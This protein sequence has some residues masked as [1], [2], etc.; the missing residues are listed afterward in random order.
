MKRALAI[1][2]LVSAILAVLLLFAGS[3]AKKIRTPAP[4]PP[5]DYFQLAEKYFD[6]ADYANAVRAY[7]TY[8]QRDPAAGNRDYVLFR[9]ALAYAFP[10]SQVRNMPRAIQ[11]LQQVVRLPE[12]RYKAQARLLLRLQEGVDKLKSDVS[13]KDERIKELTEEL[14][15]LKKIDMDRHPSRPPR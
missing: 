3:C 13:K 10:E 7:N 14:E 8:L 11:L 6:S 1:R 2:M 5:L 4:P 9:L 15:K 12:S